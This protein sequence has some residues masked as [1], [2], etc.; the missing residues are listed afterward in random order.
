MSRTK[1]RD[2]YVDVDGEPCFGEEWRAK[3]DKKKWYKP[4]KNF[5]KPRRRSE[6]AKLNNEVKNALANNKD[7]D[8]I[9]IDE[10]KN[11]DR[12]DYN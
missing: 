4:N 12:W 1:R 8:N 6:K 3:R 9:M 5:K 7:F 10:V 2:Y 11:S